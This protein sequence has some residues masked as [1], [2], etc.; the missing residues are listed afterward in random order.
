MGAQENLE[1]MLKLAEERESKGELVNT[2]EEI[3]AQER[4][5]FS[6]SVVFPGP[7]GEFEPVQNRRLRIKAKST[8]QQQDLLQLIQKERHTKTNNSLRAR[9]LKLKARVIK[10]RGEVCERCNGKTNLLWL[11]HVKWNRKNRECPSDVELL[12]KD[13][14]EAKYEGRG[15]PPI[16]LT[17]APVVDPNGKAPWED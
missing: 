8:S 1:R 4:Q 9:W 12:C 13:C 16:E 14:F 15:K 17:G 5:R 3:A 6:E 2:P 11:S 7:K 10:M